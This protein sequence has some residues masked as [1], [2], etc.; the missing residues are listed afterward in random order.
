MLGGL[1]PDRPHVYN[2]SSS[3]FKSLL[4]RRRPQSIL[5]SG[6]SGSGKTVTSKHLLSHLTFLQSSAAATKTSEPPSPQQPSPPPSSSTTSAST[7]ASRIEAT[8]PILE[9]FGNCRTRRN[10]NS[11][12]FGRLVKLLY[13]P[14]GSRIIGGEIETYLLEKVRVLGPTEGERTFNVFYELAAARCPHLDGRS[15]RCMEGGAV[16]R[17]DG[18]KDADMHDRLMKAFEVVGFAEELVDGIVSVT[19]GV[20]HISN[21]TVH[22]SE[23]EEDAAVIEGASYPCKL[24]GLKEDNFRRCVTTRRIEATGEVFVKKLTKEQVRGSLQGLMKAIYGSIFIDLVF[25]LNEELRSTPSPVTI[26]VLDIFGFEKFDV[27]SFEQLCINLCN[28]VLQQQFNKFVFKA[29]QSLYEAEGI[30]WSSI[31]FPD[32]VDV[33]DVI[34]GRFNS[35][36]S[37]LDETCLLQSSTDATFVSRVYK[38]DDPNGRLKASAK[39]KAEKAFTIKHYAGD[40]TYNSYGFVEKNKDELPREATELLSSSASPYVRV[41]CK[42]VQKYFCQHRQRSSSLANKSVG[43]QFAGQ[44]KKLSSII[45]MTDPHYIRCLKPNDDLKPNSFW[46]WLI[47]DQLKYGGVLE[48]VKVSRM[49]Y[50]NRLPKIDFFKRYKSLGKG[51]E[52]PSEIDEANVEEA[53]FDLIETMTDSFDGA[54]H[55]AP[56]ATNEHLEEQGFQIGKTLVFMKR[57]AFEKV[58]G[59]LRVK[60]QA[61]STAIQKHARRWR[62]RKRFLHILGRVLA[63]QCCYRAAVSRRRVQLLRENRAAVI[64]EAL[65]RMVSRKANYACTKRLAIVAQKLL[66]GRKGRKEYMSLSR[67]VKATLLQAC[68]RSYA[69]RKLYCALRSASVALQCML[70][71]KIARNVLK[72]RRREQQHLDTVKAENSLLKRRISTT[73]SAL[74]EKERE[75]EKLKRQMEQMHAAA[76]A[77]DTRSSSSSSS[78]AVTSGTPMEQEQVREAAAFANYS[79]PSSSSPV[80]APVIA[81]PTASTAATARAATS[82]S[83]ASLPPP[84]SSIV[85]PAS[86]PASPPPPTSSI[87]AASPSVLS[88]PPSLSSYSSYLANPPPP[89]ALTMDRQAVSTPILRY[90]ASAEKTRHKKSALHIAVLSDD[91]EAV[92]AILMGEIPAAFEGAKNLNLDVNSSL[93]HDGRTPLHSAALNSSASIVGLLL[94]NQAVANAQDNNGD[95]PLHMADDL[96]VARLLIARGRSNVNIPNNVGST[97]LHLAARRG[98]VTV[99]KLLVERGA[100]V[101]AVEYKSLRTPIFDS[102]ISG[103]LEALKIFFAGAAGAGR[104]E[105]LLNVVDKHGYTPLHLT[106]NSKQ[107]LPIASTLFQLGKVDPNVKDKHGFTPLHL[108]CAG[109]GNMCDT[110][111]LFLDKGADPSLKSR[112]GCTAIHLALYHKKFDVAKL[113]MVAGGVL[114]SP[115]NFPQKSESM[116][117]WW[118]EK[119]SFGTADSVLPFDIIEGCGDKALLRGLLSGITTPQPWVE[120][121]L[122][123]TCMIS[124]CRAEFSWNSRKHH[125]R[126]CGRICCQACTSGQVM[127]RLFPVSI[128]DDLLKRN[129]DEAHRVCYVCKEILEN[130]RSANNANGGNGYSWV[131]NLTQWGFS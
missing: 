49:G 27:N 58:E 64:I 63:I 36:L 85:V 80:A 124:E 5:V 125:C 93:D 47:A 112:D 4:E 9:S 97:P 21:V 74:E 45:E 23:T 55:S 43:S 108:L 113:L 128:Q 95:T 68:W 41:L 73:A 119:G 57:S 48:A 114:T 84:T 107:P 101:N 121:S 19:C 118:E 39:S 59:T 3:A 77:A 111:K 110:V 24:L 104:S 116:R 22:A 92:E 96:E 53:C 103:N 2:T 29:E 79:G 127:A 17:R 38:I 115:W 26:S 65:Y 52:L 25:R 15:F 37:I 56:E 30:L 28:E 117:R 71:L 1:T 75:I 91:D 70:R 87:L 14:D 78:V 123:G 106:A 6:E 54:P 62:Q 130:R 86:V 32:N 126:H 51:H 105:L 89:P 102:I 76:V 40:V 13:S 33:I 129:S 11:S 122:R 109:R 12:R 90:F 72:A 31:S 16:D 81:G 67:K 60:Q 82:P 83:V 100:D 61:S 35:V 99:A 66:R 88:T 120:D 44:L 94:E 50:P 8:Q 46:G 10:D 7:V 18:V 34:S 69:G 42:T 98:N 131:G 20:A